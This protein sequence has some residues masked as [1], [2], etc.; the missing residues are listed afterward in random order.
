MTNK[1]STC[2]PSRLLEP[3]CSELI[4]VEVIDDLPEEFKNQ[5]TC[6]FDNVHLLSVHV[7]LLVYMDRLYVDKLLPEQVL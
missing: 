6:L 4:T 7:H 3:H 2:W 5:L 1:T